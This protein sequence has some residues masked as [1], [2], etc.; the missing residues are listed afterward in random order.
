M[1]HIYSIIANKLKRRI[2]LSYENCF[3]L[4]ISILQPKFKRPLND[5][6]SFFA[7]LKEISARDLSSD[8]TLVL[9]LWEDTYWAVKSRSSDHSVLHRFQ[10]VIHAYNIESD[11]IEA[12]FESATMDVNI[13]IHSRASY[14]RYLKGSAQAV[15]LIC[16]KILV[17][18]HDETYRKMR[19]F[20]MRLGNAVQ[21]QIFLNATSEDQEHQS[22]V[23]FPNFDSNSFKTEAK[24]AIMNEIEGEFKAASE[25][26]KELPIRCRI[27]V[28]MVVSLC[29]RITKDNKIE[30]PTREGTFVKSLRIYARASTLVLGTIGVLTRL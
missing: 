12:I 16:L 11:L 14:N 8:T 17:D 6:L 10:Q 18:A 15:A 19:P 5:V 27:A 22:R 23:Y 3:K 20:A 29:K 21:K 28:N 7:A 25:G 1:N 30:K 26:I 13:R 24:T 9:Q 4:G 2:R